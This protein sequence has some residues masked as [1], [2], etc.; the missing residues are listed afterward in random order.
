MLR[1]IDHAN[2]VVSDLETATDFFSRLG[3]SVAHQ[4]YLQGEWI[5]SIVNLPDVNAS[6]V[7]LTLPNS[8]VNIELIQSA[9]PLSP[10]TEPG[11][12]PNTIGIRHLAFEVEDIETLV[13]DLK[14]E[15]VQFFGDIQTYPET[16]KMLVYFYGPDGIIL[17]LA[18]YPSK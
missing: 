13:A 17:E 18:H 5:S 1:K 14:K 11:N 16:G 8:S 4:G 15:G 12:M 3:F 9:T 2:I 10:A 7:Q 6:Y